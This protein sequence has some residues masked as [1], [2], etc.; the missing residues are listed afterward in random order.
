M[1]SPL[2]CRTYL[3]TEK[4]GVHNY[5]ELRLHFAELIANIINGVPQGQGRVLLLSPVTRQSL[6]YL[7]AN[8]C[9]LF[10][11]R[12]DVEVRSRNPQLSFNALQAMSALLC[13]GPV[14]QANGLERSSPLYRW[15]DNMLNCNETRVRGA[16]HACIQCS[17]PSS[18]CVS[19]WLQVQTLGRRTVQLL[20]QTN[21]SC[22]NLLLWVVD[23]CYDSKPAAAQLCFH[24]LSNTI[25]TL[26]VTMATKMHV[27]DNYTCMIAGP[28][29]LPLPW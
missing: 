27:H 19:L 13:C 6:F 17:R 24:A 28:A 12:V 16:Q 10:G 9:G 11:P 21:S 4:E 14:F 25:A 15:L 20:L 5:P 23:R 29:S 26:W 18:D 3:D 7:F 22:P 2:S 8:W 1:Y